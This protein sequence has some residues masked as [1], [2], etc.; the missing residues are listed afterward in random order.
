MELVDISDIKG[1]YKS[2]LLWSNRSALMLYQ[3]ENIYSLYLITLNDIIKII[4]IDLYVSEMSYCQLRQH[5]LNMIL[6]CIWDQLGFNCWEVKIK[7]QQEQI[8]YENCIDDYIYDLPLINKINNKIVS[9]SNHMIIIATLGGYTIYKPLHIQED[10]S[11]FRL[12]DGLIIIF[13]KNDNVIFYFMESSQT[14]RDVLNV[15]DVLDINLYYCLIKRNNKIIIGYNKA[16]YTFTLDLKIKSILSDDEK[17]IDTV[18]HVKSLQLSDAYILSGTFYLNQIYLL[19][20]YN[21]NKIS[22]KYKSH[23]HIINIPDLSDLIFVKMYSFEN[24][25]GVVLKTQSC[26]YLIK[27]NENIKKIK[28][29]DCELLGENNIKV[30]KSGITI[31]CLKSSMRTDFENI[32]TGPNN[33]VL[34]NTF[35]SDKYIEFP[36]KNKNIRVWCPENFIIH[37]F[38]GKNILISKGREY[39]FFKLSIGKLLFKNTDI[40]DFFLIEK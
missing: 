13:T 12:F 5:K 23:H 37:H 30:G 8:T 39:G 15:H 18:M 21:I 36:L 25:I 26:L 34:K 9:I 14:I 17:N 29:P 31:Y 2:S 1:I 6:I 19:K 33:I 11:H 22:I 32:Y 7:P 16:M 38:D 24:H 27:V 40:D 20:Y 4:D 10:I 3:N 35:T 28:V